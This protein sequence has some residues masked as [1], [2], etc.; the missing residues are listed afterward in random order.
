MK[1]KLAFI[2]INQRILAAGPGRKPIHQ[3][4][5]D[6]LERDLAVLVNKEC[7]HSELQKRKLSSM[8]NRS[9]ILSLS[10]LVSDQAGERLLGV[11]Y[12]RAEFWTH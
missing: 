3:A 2:H 10:T 6:Q 12:A 9:L 8:G 1:D 5:E 7:Q 4:T 11:I